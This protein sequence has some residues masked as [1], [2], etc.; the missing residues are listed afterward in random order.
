MHAHLRNPRSL[1]FDSL[2]SNRPIV[3]VVLALGTAL[4]VVATLVVFMLHAPVG[5]DSVLWIAGSLGMSVL[6]SMALSRWALLAWGTLGAMGIA[7]G[8]GVLAQYSTEPGRWLLS[9]G[10]V[11]SMTMTFLYHG[12]KE[13]LVACLGVWGVLGLLVPIEMNSPIDTVYVGVTWLGSLIVGAA[14]SSLFH[15]ARAENFRL[16]EQMRSLALYDEL[17]GLPN[18][19]NFLAQYDA[20]ASQTDSNGLS[21]YL[22][23]VDIDFF[24]RFNDDFG[25][26]VGDMA[27]KT[28]ARTLAQEAGE[29]CAARLGGEEFAVMGLMREPQALAFAARLNAAV[30]QCR[31]RERGITVS[32]GLAR[33]VGKESCAS[34]MRRADV[35]LYRAKTGGRNQYCVVA[36]SDESISDTQWPAVERRATRGAD[37]PS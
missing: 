9:D 18:R 14:I 23:M 31:V 33:R 16:R 3:S 35:G 7:G 29:L 17:T 10:L 28:V 24:K 12:T 8:L 4:C 13:Y 11:I 26:D 32:I 1:D 36:D 5:W 2:S 34:L 37:T 22:F 30:A 6:S 15:S 21:L 27:L 25:H 20:L 19:R